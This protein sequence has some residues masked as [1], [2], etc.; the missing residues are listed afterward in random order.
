MNPVCPHV[1]VT[2]DDTAMQRLLLDL[3]TEEGYRV[4]FVADHDIAEVK[5]LRPDVLLL[6]YRDD[7]HGSGWDFLTSLRAD[8]ETAGIPAIFLTADHQ[9][10]EAQAGPLAALAA[11]AVLKPFDLDDLVAAVAAALAGAAEPTAAT[12]ATQPGMFI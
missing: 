1:L 10:I 9:A 11:R 4:S 2:E 3:L 12:G 5:R 7:G 6:D 8:A